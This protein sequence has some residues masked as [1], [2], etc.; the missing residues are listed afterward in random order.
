MTITQLATWKPSM[1]ASFSQQNFTETNGPSDKDTAFYL[2]C[3]FS[4]LVQLQVLFGQ[5]CIFTLHLL[6]LDL[7]SRKSRHYYTKAHRLTPPNF[8][9]DQLHCFSWLMVQDADGMLPEKWK[10][11][12][13]STT[14][15]DTSPVPDNLLSFLSHLCS[16]Q[17][18]NE[19]DISLSTSQLQCHIIYISS[20]P[21]TIHQVSLL[22]QDLDKFQLRK[23]NYLE[24]WWQREF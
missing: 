14:E 17:A 5:S 15:A 7:L 8:S 23:K 10:A 22:V 18:Q 16:V 1:L 21:T 4:L 19:K 13:C 20:P 24:E 2:S 11:T 6:Q 12:A 9:A 3:P